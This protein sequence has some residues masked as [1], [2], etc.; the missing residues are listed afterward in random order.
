MSDINDLLGAAINSK[1]VDFSAALNDILQ[2]K[3]ADAIEARRIEL[4]QS[5]YSDGTEVDDVDLGLDDIDL[6]DLANLG[7]ED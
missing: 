3:A 1:P 2:D 6:E 5:L 7:T 4:A